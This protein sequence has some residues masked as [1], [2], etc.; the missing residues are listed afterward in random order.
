MDPGPMVGACCE[1]LLSLG[2][3]NLCSRLDQ[4]LAENGTPLQQISHAPL[5]PY[6]SSINQHSTK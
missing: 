4:A 6:H 1:R 5:Q 2:G 3:V